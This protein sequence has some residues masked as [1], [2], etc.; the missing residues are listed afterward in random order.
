MVLYYYSTLSP[1]SCPGYS[2][3]VKLAKEKPTFSCTLVLLAA[4]FWEPDS[5][6]TSISG[7]IFIERI[8][9]SN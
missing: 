6:D 5:D 7:Q 9:T 2:P 8:K 4:Y 3:F 1:I